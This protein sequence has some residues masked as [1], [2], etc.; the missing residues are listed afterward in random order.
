LP[1]WRVVM[2]DFT[3]TNLDLETRTFAASGLDIE[4]VAPEETRIHGLA[5]TTAGADA[6]LV[7]F[8]TIDAE[9]IQTLTSCRVISRYGIGVDMIDLD[10][11]ARAGIPVVNVPDFCIDE[12]STQTIGFLIDLNRQTLPLNAHVHERRWGSP[13]TIT[14]PRRLKGQVLGLVGLGA[15][16]KEVARKAVALGLTV[17]AHDPYAVAAP[18]SVVTMASLDDVLA[19]ADYVSLHCPLTESTRGLIGV[20]QLATMKSSAYLLNL[21]RGPVVDE[22]AL[23]QALESGVIA[24]AALDV[25]VTEPPSPEN[26]LLALDNVIITPHTSSWSIESAEQLRRGAAQNVVDA[27]RGHD[28]RSLVNRPLRPESP[29]SST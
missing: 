7:Q 3:D 8:A 5:A 26:P 23:F 20:P 19:S 21:S 27:L 11:A 4:L 16:G 25:M 17:M 24:G 12:V 13:I 22:E 15:I 28:L 9:L 14:P 10:A 29:E 6:L 18:D 2:T 1:T